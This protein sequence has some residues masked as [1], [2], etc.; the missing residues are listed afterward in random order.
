LRKK[1]KRKA[2]NKIQLLPDY[3]PRKS[4]RMGMRRLC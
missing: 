2:G 3:H 4:G 1:M